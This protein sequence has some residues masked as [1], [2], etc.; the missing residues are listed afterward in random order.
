MNKS[1]PHPKNRPILKK[2][3][4][5]GSFNFSKASSLRN[6]L[7]D[8][9]D[10]SSSTPVA[11]FLE[12]NEYRKIALFLKDKSKLFQSKKKF[13][14]I[15]NKKVS[16]QPFSKSANDV[17]I[18]GN[19]TESV[20]V[21][22]LGKA[23]EE[24]SCKGEIFNYKLYCFLCF[25]KE[26]NLYIP[27]YTPTMSQILTP[28]KLEK[29]ER[30]ASASLNDVDKTRHISGSLQPHIKGRL[31]KDI[32]NDE[33]RMN[34]IK[35]DT[36]YHKKLAFA[37]L[38]TLLFGHFDAHSGNL[39][40][41][42]RVVSNKEELKIDNIEIDERGCI[43]HKRHVLLDVKVEFFITFF[44][45]I[46]SLTHSNDVIMWGSSLRSAFRCGLFGFDVCFENCNE[47][48]L[49][50]I[51]KE[52]DR[53]DVK[54]DNYGKFVRR[55]EII[56]ILKEIPPGWFYH[57]HIQTSFKKRIKTIRDGIRNGEIKSCVDMVF[58]CHKHYKY[59]AMLYIINNLLANQKIVDKTKD[60]DE[61]EV[62][63]YEE[64]WRIGLVAA[65]TKDIVASIINCYSNG[66]SPRHMLMICRN[67]SFDPVKT[68]K[69]IHKK[70]IYPASLNGILDEIKKMLE[71]NRTLK[72]SYLKTPREK[73]T[74]KIISKPRIKSLKKCLVRLSDKLN[75]YPD[76]F[77]EL[78]NH[79]EECLLVS[80]EL[81]NKNSDK[82]LPKKEF[83]KGNFTDLYYRI[84]YVKDNIKIIEQTIQDYLE[85]TL[86]N[87][88][89]IEYVVEYFYSRSLPDLKDISRDYI[90]EMIDNYLEE[91]F[92]LFHVNFYDN[93]ESKTFPC[94]E[95]WDDNGYFLRYKKRKRVRIEVL[96]VSS[97]P[98]FIIMK[99]MTFTVEQFKKYLD[100]M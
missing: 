34:L 52:L 64:Y 93:E 65:S 46:R 37:M 24:A 59:F 72:P 78:I 38:Y 62:V 16:F 21:L 3:R 98:G 29:F 15:I 70:I 32:L 83:L 39:M 20:G 22:K 56:D 92:Q 86:G 43:I 100:D 17:Y 87:N 4:D 27:Q 44:D 33:K 57:D 35:K 25:E 77:E 41:D 66:I 23:G 42:I 84:E 31:L 61:Q 26:V 63:N 55:E 10:S 5:S 99:K 45:N 9:S 7:S 96:D 82:E 88:D 71:Y 95:R 80:K 11:E 73:G 53:I 89:D 76:D 19:G 58:T 36:N 47:N 94:I 75:E 60:L 67:K 2:M 14:M 81:Q 85:S 49:F 79:I 28:K 74:K 12:K 48:I 90:P 1:A 91:A 6:Y 50:E 13:D 18:L 54:M 51:L 30:R 40:I 68:L 69:D 97:Q 8:L